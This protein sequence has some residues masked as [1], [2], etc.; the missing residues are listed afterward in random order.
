[1]VG[2]CFTALCKPKAHT[3]RQK[4]CRWQHIVHLPD[5]GSESGFQP[6]AGNNFKKINL[7]L[8]GCYCIRGLCIYIHTLV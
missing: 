3:H 7:I 2:N 1:M 8:Q 6:I 4:A 5:P